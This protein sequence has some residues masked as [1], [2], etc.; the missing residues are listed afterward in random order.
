[1]KKFKFPLVMIEWE[2]SVL[3]FQGWKFIEEQPK[4]LTTF[5]SVGFLVHDDNRCKILYPHIDSSKDNITG[6]GD[7]IIPNSAI[8]KL[9]LLR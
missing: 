6:S 8:R 7:I 2:D 9:T 5:L 4:E 3:G 1:M